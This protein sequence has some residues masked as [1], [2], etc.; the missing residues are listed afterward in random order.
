[1]CSLVYY[2]TVLEQWLLYGVPVGLCL[3]SKAKLSIDTFVRNIKQYKALGGK[4]IFI[5]KINIHSLHFISSRC[6]FLL[7]S[8]HWIYA[9]K[10]YT[11]RIFGIMLSVRSKSLEKLIIFRELQT[12]F[13][14]SMVDKWTNFIP[15][16]F[17]VWKRS[18]VGM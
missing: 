9:G 5:F 15:N 13:K 2:T 6:D 10:V 3:H 12:M 8:P 11:C 1:M 4:Y 18:Q 16:I 14:F 7:H 17:G